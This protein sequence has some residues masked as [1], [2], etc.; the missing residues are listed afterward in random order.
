MI[1][2]Q[3][4]ED[5]AGGPFT[6]AAVWHVKRE[7]VVQF[8]ALLQ[9]IVAA[10][11]VFPGH[12]GVHAVTPAASSPPVYRVVVRFGSKKQFLYWQQ[13][14]VCQELIAKAST[15]AASPADLQMKTGLEAW[16]Q[17][18]AGVNASPPIYKT[19]ILMWLVLFPLTLFCQ[20]VL[21]LMNLHLSPLIATGIT[22]AFE[23]ALVSYLLMPALARILGS[24]LYTR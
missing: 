19:S 13:S 3:V 24:W 4:D 10:A 21:V 11:A 14:D 8:E 22:M 18:P 20:W 17:D 16:F 12:E 5:S 2:E 1:L 6:F 9:K 23:I 15:L 7:C